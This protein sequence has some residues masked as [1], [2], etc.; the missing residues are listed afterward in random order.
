MAYLATYQKVISEAFE[1]VVR[2]HVGW[3]E[4]EGVNVRICGL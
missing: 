1:G 2:E 4:S 3:E